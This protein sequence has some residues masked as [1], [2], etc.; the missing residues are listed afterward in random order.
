MR[1]QENDF[2]LERCS[3][4]QQMQIWPVTEVIDYQ[5]WLRNFSK[6]EKTIAK[7]ILSAF[8]YFPQPM[9]NHM[10]IT[11]VGYAGKEISKVFNNW[12]HEDFKNRCLY[13]IVPG[14]NPNISDSGFSFSR[15]L[16]E[17]LH[18][19]E[20]RMK[21]FNELVEILR[22]TTDQIVILVDDFV[23]SGEQCINMWFQIEGAVKANSHLI[24]YAPLII[25]HIG[26][27]RI[28]ENCPDIILTPAH[29]LGP[30]Y[31]LFNQSCRCWG[32]E[33]EYKS[34]LEI[35][36]KKSRQ[37]GVPM[38]NETDTAY[39]KGFYAQG[40]SLAFSHG[41]P[42]AI[43]PLFYWQENRWNPLVNKTYHR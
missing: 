33:E 20:G 4:F 32:N 23:G 22:K 5:G 28:K 1:K 37:I 13:S 12:K 38:I 30:E 35:I 3:L 36:E 43:L 19:P 15:I 26:E 41:A 39:Y 42:D 11:S 24:V 7:K 6:E 9:I 34:G 18:I 10:L 2:V 16:K 31:N 25:N 14:E 40:L 27:K 21:F 29:Y 17:Q 8:M